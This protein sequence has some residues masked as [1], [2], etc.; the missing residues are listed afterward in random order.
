M[1]ALRATL[2][3]LA[4]ACHG[5][6]H[7]DGEHDH[8]HGEEDGGRPALSFTDW[9]D[10]SELFIEFDALVVGEESPCAAHVTKLDGFEAPEE[11]EVTVVLRDESGAEE[12][13]TADAPTQPGIFRPVAL[14]ARAG[15]R[16][17]LVEVST[18]G[19]YA[20]HD[21]GPVT[22]YETAGAA[23]EDIPEEDD[24]PGRI[25]FLKEQQWPIAFG[26]EEVQRQALR[27]TL[28]AAGAIRARADGDVVI[29]APVAGRV[30][31]A[32]GGFARLG[33]QVA[34]DDLVAVI[35]PRLE[36]ADLASLELAVTSAGLEARF[37]DRE[38]ERLE[39]LRAQGAVPDRRVDDAARAAEEAGAAR[40][41]AER[42]LAQFRR[43]Q[44]TTGRGAGAV[45]LRAP[46]AGTITS[47]DVAPGAFVEA[48]APLFRITDLRSLWVEVQVPEIDVPRLGTV[49]G[50]SVWVE[51]FE[52]AFD[53]GPEAI[54]AR[55]SVIDAVTRTLPLLLA[56]DN[57][58]GRLAVGAYARVFLV[59]GEPREAIAVP[60]SAIVD[61]TGIP[62]AFVQVEG[63][64]FERRALRLG[65]RDRGLVEVVSGLHEGEHV[66]TVGAW[67]VKLAASSGAVPAH[68]HSH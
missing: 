3:A 52:Q 67:S 28:R 23:I 4:C 54:V 38:R 42:R 16:T 60:Q 56:V 47:V 34:I 46:L 48:G 40:A 55:G 41:A 43:V 13:F 44:G 58:G 61:D 27:P 57:A 49:T 7:G 66:V 24:P 25:T 22:V 8:A 37:A 65:I 59:N 50:A 10:G 32:E 11:G 19:M 26:T 14:P 45:Q 18:P 1:N 51:G 6:D 30:A 39:G 53:L 63:E 35:A 31:S 20:T 12:R 17:L 21:L 68:G 33:A 5:H 15:P 2:L 36:A 9:Q 29:T 64:A 62:V